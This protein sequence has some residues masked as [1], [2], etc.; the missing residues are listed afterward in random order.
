MGHGKW[1]NENYADYAVNTSSLSRSALYHK[2]GKDDVSKSGQRVNVEEIPYRESRDSESNPLSTPVI[3]ALDVTGSMGM[4]P[5]RLTKEGLGTFVGQMLEREPIQDPHIC[6]LGIGDAV[7]NDRAPLQA[8]QF[9]ADNCICEQLTDLWLEGGGGGNHFESY[10]L[11]WAF[12]AYKTRT[13]AWDKRKEYGYLFTVG[14][15]EFP[16]STSSTYLKDTFKDDCPQSPTPESLLKD[17]QERYRVFHVIIAEGSYASRNLPKTTS[18]W[19]QRLQKRVLVLD[20][21]ECLPELL[22]SV[23]AVD[24]GQSLE[25][26]LEW[27]DTNVAESI[28]RAIE[29]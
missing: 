29:E 23:M 28:K 25:D 16:Q 2:R 14:D 18:S 21:Y 4:I 6:F 20:N 27:W 9:E 7:Q 5:E 19:Q 1:S 12:A 13:D 22:V 24:K 8:T 15:E 26:V 17:A 3:V 10:D 11:A